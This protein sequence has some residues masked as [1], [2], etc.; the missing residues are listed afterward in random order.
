MLRKVNPSSLSGALDIIVIEH[1]D[2]TLRSSPWHLTFGKFGLFYHTNKFI[3]VSVNDTPA[4]FM[5]YVDKDGRGQFFASQTTSQANK[6]QTQQ[7]SF[8]T[9]SLPTASISPADVRKI[10][11]A[12]SPSKKKEPTSP[13][14]HKNIENEENFSTFITRN[15]AV[16]LEAA[17]IYDDLD[18]EPITT[19]ASSLD[20]AQ[21][22]GRNQEDLVRGPKMEAPVPSAIILNS[23][24]PL[25]HQGENRIDFTVSSLLQGP[26]TIV[27]YLHLWPSDAKIVISD[28]DGTVTKSDVLGQVLPSIGKDWT[29]PGLAK[30]YQTISQQNIQIIYMSS[31]PIGE[32]NYTRNY[33]KGIEQDG[34]KLPAGPLITCPSTLF[35]AIS[36]ELIKKEPHIF[37][38]SAI[39]TI[40]Q[41][42]DAEKSPFVF[43]FG[44]KNTDV[45]AYSTNEMIP[46][47]HI[48]LFNKKHK[49]SDADGN[50]LFSSIEE[51]QK[52]IIEIFSREKIV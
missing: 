25:I 9:V 35:P 37:K 39:R 43:G 42:F 33:L 19:A 47:K 23:L 36:M 4:P 34:V 11:N 40:F 3:S 41:L 38:I 26:K 52:H 29:H 31:R 18:P 51:L 20:L 1:K 13:K 50:P 14:K 28:V 46:K 8:P 15:S 21:T 32:A 6:R 17:F 45:I 27:S 12:S 48:F 44:N 5:M 2:G 22:I 10:L 30:L 7:S 49:V 16:D 24:R